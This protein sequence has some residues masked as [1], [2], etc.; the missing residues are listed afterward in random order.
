MIV[1]S[2]AGAAVAA[3]SFYVKLGMKD[4]LFTEDKLC[5]LEGADCI[6]VLGAG[7]TGSD[8]SA[9]L[10]GRLD[11]AIAL[12]KKGAA[13]KLIMSGDHARDGYDEVN[14]MKDYA[15]GAG[16]PSEDVFMDHAGISTY[17]SI[18]RARDIFQVKK[19]IVVT[20]RYHQYRAL[21]IAKHLGVEAY[22]VDAEL[23]ERGATFGRELRE[24][25][26]RAKDV[27]KCVFKP[28]A[29]ILGEAIP[30]NGDG[31]VTND[32]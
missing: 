30:V 10:C 23:L 19:M 16:V 29:R 18:Y 14:V 11:E 20:Q 9:V 31:N 6:L 4:R 13:P 12:Y 26:A 32:R 3:L 28:E 17:D 27:V 22:G 15:V 24:V 25:V 7:V 1:V 8:P 2:V 21:Y 5:E